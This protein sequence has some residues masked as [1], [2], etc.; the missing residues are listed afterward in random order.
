MQR[1]LSHDEVDA[2]IARE[3]V[4]G[5]KIGFTC[6]AFDILHAGHV[7]YLEKARSMCDRLLVAVNS[8]DS[9]RRY[10]HPLRPVVGQEHRLRLIAALRCVDAVTLLDDT[11]PIGLIERWRPDYYIKGGDYSP[12]DLRSAG[13]V[14]AYGG[15]VIVCPME[16]RLSTTALIEKIGHLALYGDPEMLPVQT[17][18]LALLDRDGTLIRNI[19]FLKDP[20]R[21][22]LLPGVGE[23]LADLQR[24]GF[25]LAIVTNQ[26]GIGLGYCSY[27]EFIAVNQAMLRLLAPYGIRISK[28]Y[29]CPHA[30]GDNCSCRKP[31]ADLIRRALRDFGVEAQEC[32]V[33]GD[34]ESDRIAAATVG[35]HAFVTPGA[36]DARAFLDTVAAIK[37]ALVF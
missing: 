4:H 9:I 8:D 27:D 16:Y 37:A 32:Y 22:E 5:N 3:R 12:S 13:D 6:G 29:F 35:C 36:E 25:R 33:I 7:Q 24:L 11:R 31:G 30:V 28:I 15:A 2:W 21:V 17:G 19:P 18:P 10:K 34:A 14:E 1:I 23:G 26:Q 20:S